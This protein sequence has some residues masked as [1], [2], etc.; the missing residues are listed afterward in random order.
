[1]IVVP[2]LTAPA[3]VL[4]D[5]YAT[6]D[7]GQ[8]FLDESAPGEFSLTAG[9]FKTPFGLNR[10]VTPPQLTSVEY[11]SISSAVFTDKTFWDDGLMATYKG[12]AFR[13]DV[14]AV[15]GLGPNLF[16]AP[17]N[18][19]SPNQDYLGRLEVPLFDGQLTL[20]ASYYYGTHFTTAGTQAFSTAKNWFGAHAKWKGLPKTYDLEFEWITRESEMFGINGQAAFWLFANIQPF[21]L[22]EY[23]ENHQ[24]E[25][26]STGRM[27]G[28]FNWYPKTA[29]PLRITLETIGES[30][31]YWA[32]DPFHLSSGKTILQTQVTF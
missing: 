19:S 6:L 1:V 2:E 30:Q 7:F 17:F 21:V 4:L 15:K 32:G 26:L 24:K 23:V 31:G 12:K 5:G 29:G 11:S 25:S 20:G 13:L 22:Y 8:V 27:G 16:T 14:A 28:G 18:L 3:F 9:Q 10:M